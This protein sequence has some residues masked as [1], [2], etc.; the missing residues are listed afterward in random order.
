M[1]G[2]SWVSND[3]A[4]TTFLLELESKGFRVQYIWLNRLQVQTFPTLTTC[5]KQHLPI[6]VTVW[7][8][9]SLLHCNCL[10]HSLLGCECYCKKRR[11][12]RCAP[13]QGHCSEDTLN[14]F[15]KQ[16]LCVAVHGAEAVLPSW[17]WGGRRE[18]GGG[19][20]F[21]ILFYFIKNSKQRARSVDL[22]WMSR[23]LNECKYVNKWLNETENAKEKKIIKQR[24]NACRLLL[25]ARFQLSCR[26]SITFLPSLRCDYYCITESASG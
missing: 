9:A 2:F 10:V 4:V 14:L 6:C 1:Q 17:R 24:K 20:C 15:I 26:M 23:R 16:L 13:K 22:T 18:E 25:R 7:Y 12:S 8:S 3:C 5:L 19:E 21:F 11:V